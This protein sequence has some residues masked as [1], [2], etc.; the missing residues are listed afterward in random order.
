MDAAY[1]GDRTLAVNDTRAQLCDGAIRFISF[2]GSLL[3]IVHY[4]LLFYPCE[5]LHSCGLVNHMHM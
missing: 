5:G 2:V 1:P 3:K 4:V